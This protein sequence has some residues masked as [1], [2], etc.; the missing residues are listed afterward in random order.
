MIVNCVFEG[1]S[2]SLNVL[3]N[4]ICIQHRGASTEAHTVHTIWHSDGDHIASRRN[5]RCHWSIVD[6]TLRSYSTDKAT[7]LRLPIVFLYHVNKGG[8]RYLPCY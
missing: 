2:R 5:S 4:F 6:L 7:R 1:K 3:S 8:S